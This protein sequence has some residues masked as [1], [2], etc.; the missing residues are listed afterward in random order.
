MAYGRR[1]YR[2]YNPIKQNSN[3]IVALQKQST[4]FKNIPFFSVVVFFG[5][6]E[7]KEI[8]FVPERTYLVK[9]NR[10]FEVLD[11]I[12]SS[13]IPAPYIDKYEVLRILKEGVNLGGNVDNQRK[14]KEDIRNMLGHNR[15][16]D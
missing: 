14:H 13:N 16:F 2:F 7:L 5:N 12:K 10:I 9:S 4:Q 6:C 11:Q 8:D 1:K 15:I 3:H